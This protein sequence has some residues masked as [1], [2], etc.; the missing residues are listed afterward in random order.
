MSQSQD[1]SV[2]RHPPIREQVANILRHAIISLDFRPGEVL[3]ERE[4]C[5]RTG[6]SRPSVREALRQL[7]AE[8]L[9]ESRNGRGTIVKILTPQEVENVYE[10]RAELEGLGARLFCERA[11]DAQRDQLQQALQSLQAAT[12]QGVA[13]SAEIL[14][15]QYEFYSVLF[16]GAQNELLDQLVQGLQGRI[17]QLRA[18]TLTFPGRAEESLAEFAR[19][20]QAIDERDAARAELAAVDHVRAAGA[21]MKSVP[22]V[23]EAVGKA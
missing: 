5:E 22:Y 13:N 7:E 9:V 6:A 14:A 16:V 17:A 11:S 20:V 3:I 8:G 23:E 19:V 4:L 15:A 2:H 18:T 10:V 1:L 21:V 12:G